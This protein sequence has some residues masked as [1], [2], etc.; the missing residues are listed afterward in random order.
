MAKTKITITIDEKYVSDLDRISRIKRANR[1]ALIEEAIKL[2]EKEQIKHA[3]KHGYQI[4]AKED[5]K[6]ASEYIKIARE[7]LN[8]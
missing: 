3:L 8:E 4:M 5:S 6:A 7:I 1:S 2:W